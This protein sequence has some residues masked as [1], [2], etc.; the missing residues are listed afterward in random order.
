VS[1]EALQRVPEFVWRRFQPQP[2]EF[3]GWHPTYAA[4]GETPYW[5]YE[6]GGPVADRLALTVR[7][8]VSETDRDLMQL[9]GEDFA[10]RPGDCL[11]VLQ[12]RIEEATDDIAPSYLED[13]EEAS[14]LQG[15][16]DE[17]IEERKAGTLEAALWKLKEPRGAPWSPS[18][19][20]TSREREAG[21]SLEAIAQSHQ[22]RP[23]AISS[24]IDTLELG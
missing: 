22:R 6:D 3:T 13:D 21:M 2:G 24:R 11:R 17:F 5:N 9:E 1:I 19:E 12:F 18:R 20:Y 7:D 14:W 23:G 10:Q 4:P 16:N 15:L 8:S